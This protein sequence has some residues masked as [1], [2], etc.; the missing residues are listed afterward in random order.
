MTCW[1]QD[2]L[3]VEQLRNV[4]IGKR[5]IQNQSKSVAQKLE[6]G[7]RES[8]I[9]FNAKKKSRSKSFNVVI[10]V[11]VALASIVTLQ[12]HPVGS[13]SVNS[14]CVSL[15][16]NGIRRQ[17]QENEISAQSGA[18]PVVDDNES[19]CFV[20]PFKTTNQSLLMTDRCSS[21][22]FFRLTKLMG[23]RDET[24]FAAY[25]ENSL[26]DSIKRKSLVIHDM[27]MTTLKPEQCLNDSVLNFWFKWITTPRSPHDQASSVYICSTYLLSGV[28]TEGYSDRMKKFLNKVNIFKKKI[29]MF[30]VHLAHHWSLVAVLNPN[31]IQQTKTRWGDSSYTRDITAMIHL[32]SLGSGTV[33]SRKLVAQAVRNVLNAE[34]R[35]HHGTTL[36]SSYQMP[37]THRH[38]SF[39]LHCPKGECNLFGFHFHCA[40]LSTAFVLSL[41][42]IGLIC[43]SSSVSV[44]VF[45]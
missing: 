20:L 30:P 22:L 42:Y 44:S 14:Y 21:D 26:A 18:A 1:L 37:F 24:S 34:W 28:L 35:R 41:T 45:F 12:K 4:G 40:E 19:Q 5:V 2:A 8:R 31:L 33:H 27:D 15:V 10:V 16:K 3:G 11:V 36:D 6:D 38:K 13:S 7:H 23:N 9:Q 29:V 39:Q 17:S 32:D 25:F 43:H